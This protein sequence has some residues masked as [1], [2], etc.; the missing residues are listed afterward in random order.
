MYVGDLLIAGNRRASIDRI[1]G[2]FKKRFKMKDNGEASEVFGLEIERNHE[3]K[4]L[5]VH[6]NR[7]LRL[8]SNDLI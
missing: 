7:M 4:T 2:E 1:K 6:K 8:F 5:L 3:N